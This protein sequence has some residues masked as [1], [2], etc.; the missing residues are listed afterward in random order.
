MI[1][2]LE[3]SVIK[4]NI[5]EL[6]KWIWKVL[7]NLLRKTAKSQTKK[8]SKWTKDKEKKNAKILLIDTQK[9]TENCN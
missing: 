1:A 9:L 3:K 4:L 8:V 2:S 7:Y 5:D 6:I